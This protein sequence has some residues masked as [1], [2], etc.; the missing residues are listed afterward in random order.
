[1]ESSSAGR[2]RVL[3]RPRNDGELLLIDV[4]SFDPTYVPVGDDGPAADLPPG[5]LIEAR[6]RWRDGTPRFDAV[7]VADRTLF[8]FESGITGVFEAARETWQAA[9]RAGDAMNSRVT[10]N[11][12]GEP[13]GAL[14]VFAKQSGAR[15]L[16]EEFRTGVRPLEP[17]LDRVDAD[18]DDD[19]PREVFVLRP[20]DEPF[21]LVYI[22]FEKGGRLADT[23]RDTYDCPRPREPEA[24]PTAADAPIVEADDDSTEGVDA[25]DGGDADPGADE[26]PEAHGDV[27]D[28]GSADERERDDVD[29]WASDP[30]GRAAD[31]ADPWADDA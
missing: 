9:E 12:D 19:G 3:G 14:Y 28:D 30:D 23:V 13:N 26:T 27:G 17:L 20:A 4:E 5:Y 31:D 29:P 10:R 1:M 25:K 2:Y 22:A 24:M 7:S 16:F 11:V 8:T 21:V 6:L 15:D 18:R